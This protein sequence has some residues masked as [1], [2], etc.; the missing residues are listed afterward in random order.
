MNQ[1][2]DHLSTVNA[3]S[4]GKVQFVEYLLRYLVQFLCGEYNV[5]HFLTYQAILLTIIF[6]F[7]RYNIRHP[8][9]PLKRRVYVVSVWIIGWQSISAYLQYVASIDYAFISH[10]NIWQ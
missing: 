7:L 6:H 1:F 9:M 4:W 10:I 5:F 2:H 3:L 8:F